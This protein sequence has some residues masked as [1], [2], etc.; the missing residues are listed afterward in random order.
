MDFGFTC[1]PRRILWIETTT[2]GEPSGIGGG[3]GDSHVEL[4][5]DGE[6][7][8]DYQSARDLESEDPQLHRHLAKAYRAGGDSEKAQEALDKASV[9]EYYNQALEHI[10]SGK[11][12]PAVEGLKQRLQI[13]ATPSEAYYELGLALV[14]LHLMDEGLTHLKRYLELAPNG[15]NAQTAKALLEELGKPRH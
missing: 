10:E 11:N 5:Q 7:L 9:L 8:Q 15:P 14:G 4:Q 6:A 13:D 3:V 12:R 1:Y 2:R